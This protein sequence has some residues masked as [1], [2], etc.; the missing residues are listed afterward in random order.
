M[1]L[2]K[3][4]GKQEYMDRAREKYKEKIQKNLLEDERHN[5]KHHLHNYSNQTKLKRK[6]NASQQLNL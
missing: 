3:M 2:C 4:W 1:I 5:V 6:K